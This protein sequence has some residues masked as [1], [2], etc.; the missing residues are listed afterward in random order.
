MPF[1]QETDV[2][3]K[4]FRRPDHVGDVVGTSG[5]R[6]GVRGIDRAGSATDQRSGAVVERSFY[7]FWGDEVHV[8]INRTGGDDLAF[9]ANNLGAH[10]DH[11]VDIVHDVWVTGVADLQ[12]LAVFDC[13]ICGKNAGVVDDR[14]VGD[15]QVWHHIVTAH[16]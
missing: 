4:V 2:D 13:N 5:N 14:S 7:L 8:G 6:G 12:N 9:A 1:A 16:A 11:D 3:G 10:A 15:H